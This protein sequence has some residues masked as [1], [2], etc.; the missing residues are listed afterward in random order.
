[1]KTK[2]KEMKRDLTLDR[3]VSLSPGEKLTLKIYPYEH[4]SST[5]SLWMISYRYY[6]F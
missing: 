5:L 3:K 4:Q 6:P 1:M 2:D